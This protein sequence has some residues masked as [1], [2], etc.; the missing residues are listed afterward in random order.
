MRHLNPGPRGGYSD[1]DEPLRP[2]PR[3]RSSQV[4]GAQQLTKHAA[5]P[6][7]HGLKPVALNAFE[8]GNCEPG[9]CWKRLP[10]DSGW[11]GCKPYMPAG[12]GQKC[13]WDAQQAAAR[14][15]AGSSGQ[16][17]VRGAEGS[18]AI[19]TY[20]NNAGVYL[21]MPNA[22]KAERSNSRGQ[23]VKALPCL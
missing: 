11:H 22:H 15:A 12:T 17:A 20:V 3:G 14:H 23:S 16:K 10:A 2:N 18:A 19:A 6:P 21:D 4:T 7:S 9:P 8:G 1:D 5:S 13:C